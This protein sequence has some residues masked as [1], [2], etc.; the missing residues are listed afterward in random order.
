MK[1]RHVPFGYYFKLSDK[2]FSLIGTIFTLSSVLLLLPFTFFIMS[3]LPEGV[4]EN[5]TDVYKNGTLTEAQ[6]INVSV[7]SEMTINNANPSKIT[8]RYEDHGL[9]MESS[10][11]TLNRTVADTL[12]TGSR[13]PVKVYKGRAA[14]VGMENVNFPF[15]LFFLLPGIFFII[16]SI[17]A[18]KGYYPVMRRVKLLKN[19]VARQGHITTLLV[20]Q[21]LPVS[22]IGRK[23]FVYYYYF[24]RNGN[25]IAAEDVTP[26]MQLL[27]FYKPED[28]ITIVVDR[29]NENNSCLVPQDLAKL[30]EWRI[31]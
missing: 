27:A 12:K 18:F 5:Y 4:T 14:I 8:L 3:M 7:L 20:N 9:V 30:P 31:G 28:T 2:R 10:F 26:E 23:L 21:G 16:G 6:V 22:G 17:F 15:E 25:K 13:L 29:E 11:S 1:Q 24:D 19:G